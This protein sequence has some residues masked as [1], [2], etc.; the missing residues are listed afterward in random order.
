[1][2]S[3]SQAKPTVKTRVCMISDTHTAT[4]FP[5][6]ALNKA[7]RY[8]LPKSD[9]FLHAGDLT[10]TGRQAEHEVIVDMLRRDVDAE[11]KLVIAGNH[12]LTHDKE[13]YA[14]KGLMRHGSARLEDPDA[15]RALYT[16]ESARNAGIVYMEEEVRT[17]SLKN[18]A[19]FTV[20]ASPYTPEFFGWAFAY[21]RDE[22]RFN[23]STPMS[24]RN[25]KTW[26]PSFPDVDIMLTHGPPLGF[27]DDVGGMR[28]GVG[29]ES[30]LK[31]CER[32]RPRLHVFGHIHE[33]FGAVRHNWSNDNDND[34]DSDAGEISLDFDTALEQR[35]YSYDMSSDAKKPLKFGEETLFV[36]AS[37]V[38]VRYHANNAPWVVDL[39]L[40]LAT[41]Q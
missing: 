28:K 39:D 25:V 29:C 33:G 32:A 19:R 40:P 31:A 10:R 6:G 4:P 1:M 7:Y 30:L 8:P 20:Y 27:L 16:D 22:D 18:G 9:I 36:N 21:E 26:V 11:L 24:S 5:A 15:N 35:C 41:S 37:V 12:D 2:S 14:R 23:P 34:N 3:E 38:T 17:F 13:Y